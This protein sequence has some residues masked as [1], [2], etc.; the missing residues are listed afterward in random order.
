MS[1]D[2]LTATIALLEKANE[3]G[4]RITIDNGELIV[5]LDE[6]KEIDSSFL[7]E[8]KHNKTQLIA[9]LHEVGQSEQEIAADKSITAF[10]RNGLINIPLSYSQERLWFIDQLEGSAHYHIPAVLRLNGQ[11]N[12][13]ALTWSLQAIV[14]RH[15]VLRTVVDTTAGAAYQRIQEKDNWQLTRIDE[16][17]Y[18]TD[19]AALQSLIRSLI[20]IPFD[21]SAH[22]MLRAHLIRIGEAEHILVA[23]MHHI[24][25]DGWSMGII[26]RELG[27]LYNAY[28]TGHTAVLPPLDIQ[29]ADYAIWQRDYLSAPK[30]KTTLEYWE[31]KLAGVTTLQLPTDYVRP[32]VQRNQGATVSFD[33]D[34][35]LSDLLRQLSHQQGATLFMT[36]L[37]AFKVLLYRYTGQEDSCIGSP[38]AGRNRQELEG[39][40]GI[41]INTLALRSDLGNQ[42][43][44]ISLLQQVK[45]TTLAAYDHQEVPF[46]KIVEAVVKE[47]DMDRHPLFQVVFSLQNTPPVPALR[48]GEVELL[49]VEVE[50]VTAQ[51]DLSLSM[52]ETAAGLSGSIVYNVDLFSRETIV[53]MTTH[54][55]QLLRSVAAAPHSQIGSLTLLTADEAQQLQI[56]FNDTATIFPKEKTVADLFTSQA[57]ATPGATAVLWGT[58]SLT[59]GELDVRSTQLAHYLRGKGI[60]PEI[61]VAVCMTPSLEMIVGIL[62]IMKA[63]GIY[64]P[65]D[66]EYPAERIGYIIADTGANI[67]LSND[68]LVPALKAA[69]PL[70]EIIPADGGWS[71]VDSYPATALATRPS[72]EHLAYVIYTSGSTG[73]PKGVQA[74]HRSL[75]NLIYCQSRAYNIKK[76][77][78][79]LLLSNSSFDAAIEQIFFALL[80]G[81]ALVLVTREIL[82]DIHLFEQLLS[83]QQI[84]HL[85]ATNGFLVHVTPGRYNGL[86]R[87]I[88]GGEQ[89]QVALAEKWSRFVDFYNI[90]GPT[91]TTISA[92]VYRYVPDSLHHLSA[93]PIG[94]PLPN[95][96]VYILDAHGALAPIGVAG[97]I[98]IGGEGVTRGYL[99]RPDLNAEKFIEDTFSNNT[100]AKMYAT[101]DIGKWLPDGTIVFLGRKDEQVKIRG[102][103]IE[104]AEIALVLE[105]SPLAKQAVVVAGSEQGRDQQVY[106]RLTGYI[107]PDGVLDIEEIYAY[108]ES[109][110]PAHMIPSFIVA[111]PEFPL[112]ANGKIDKKALP[113]PNGE[114][115]HKNGYVAPRDKTEQQLAQIWQDLLGVSQ[116]GIHDSF[117]KLGGHSLLVMRLMSVM[118]KELDTVVSMKN[119]FLHPTIAG[120]SAY[121]KAQHNN[122]ALPPVV[123]VVRPAHIPLSYSQERLWFIDQ[124]EGSV[125]YHIPALL[126]LEGNL[127]IAALSRALQTIINR[128]EV[129]RTVIEQEDGIACQRVLDKDLWKLP[130]IDELVYKT[131]EAALQDYVRTLINTP[132]DLSADH[133][134]RGHLI[135]LDEN[136]YQL[137]ITLHHIAADA[138][139]ISI[140]VQ[141]LVAL[142]EAYT[143]GRPLQLAPLPVQYVDYAIWQ[144]THLSG[145]VLERKLDYWKEKLTGVKVLALPVDFRQPPLQSMD[146]GKITFG[147]DSHLSGQLQELSN[148]QGTTLFMT[149]LTVFKV[150]LY[151][152]TGQ[153]DI[154]VGCSTAV[155]PQQVLDGLIGFFVNTLA[156]RSHL[157]GDSTFVSLLQQVKITTLDAYDHADAPFEKVVETVVK[158]RG[159][160]RNPLFRVMFVMQQGADTPELRLGNVILSGDTTEHTTAKFDINFSIVES[161]DGL[162]IGITYRNDLFRAE[163]IAGMAKHFEQLLLSVVENPAAEISLLSMLS[164]TEVGRLQEISGNGVTVTRAVAG[165]N[166]ADLFSAQ[167]RRTPS[168]TALVFESSTLRYHELEEQ[169][170]QLAHHLRNLG[171]KTGTLVPLCIER[172][173]EM[174]VGL[175]GILKAG[176]AY[177]PVDPDYPQ[178]I[179]YML[180]DTRAKVVVSSATCR[181]LFGTGEGM[182]I[183]ALDEDKDT[184]SRY[185]VTSVAAAVE[186]ADL[187]YVIYTSGSTGNP[188]GVMISHGNLLDYL[189]GLEAALPISGCQSFAL[190]AGISTD[191]GNT[192]LYHALTSGGSLHLF[193]R[194]MINDSETLQAY[195]SAHVIDCLKIVPSHWKAL[196]S[197]GD[198]LLPAKL[199]I[200]GGEVLDAGVTA[201][202]F[203]SGSNCMVVNHY[204]PTETTIG[205]LL[206]IVEREREYDQYIPIGRPFSNSQAYV[207]SDRL[208]RCPVGIPGELYIG[209][210]GVGRGYLNNAEL[211]SER[212]IADPFNSG[213][214]LYR[215][216]DI[217]KYLPDGNIMFIG[218]RDDQLK[219]RGYRVELEEIARVLED[220]PG[221]LQG[222]VVYQGEEGGL[223]R[224]TGYV[225]TTAGYNRNAVEAY[226]QERLPDYMIP[227]ALV[228]M[229]EFPLLANGKIDRK[230]LRAPVTDGG[231]LDNGAPESVREQQLAD[232]W[233]SLLEMEQV[234]RQDNFF[235]LGGHS[236]LAIRLVSAIRKTL[237]VEVSIGDIFDYP[238]IAT[239]SAHLDQTSDRPVLSVIRRYN[240]RPDRIPLS[241]SQ[242]R[243]WFID[244]L[245]G[246]V[247]YH[248]PHVLRL[249]GQLNRE[250]LANALQEI[251]N[252]HDVLRTVMVQQ[253]G[254]AYQRTQDK[255]LWELSVVNN[256]VY[257]DDP[258]ALQDFT[259]SLID[260]PFDLSQ[261]HMLRAHLI[262]LTPEEYVL[263]VTMH[264]I[265]SDA[266]SKSIIVRE[267]AELYSAGVDNRPAQLPA[268]SIQYTDY[269]IWQR[270]YLSAEILAQK[271]GYWKNKLTDIA[272]LQLPTDYARPVFQS[273]RGAGYNF[274]LSRELAD[275]L[276]ALSRQQD[277]TL[278]MTLLTAFNILL[279]RY[280]G[281]E[282]ICVG[283]SIA[284]RSQSELEGLIGF[285]IN[286]LALRTDVGNDPA[287]TALLKQVKQ[288]TLEA[289]DHQEIPFERIVEVVEKDRDMSRTSL[290]QVMFE[291]FNTP[292]A[293]GIDLKDLQLSSDHVE[294]ITTL[295]DMGVSFV[296]LEDGLSGHVEYCADLFSRDT[297]SRMMGHFVQLLQAI[298]QTPGANISA[299]TMLSPE[300]EHKL[301]TTFNDTVFFYPHDK[302]L[303]ALFG[304]QAFRKPDAV[305]VW[306]EGNPLSYRE[307]DRQSDQLAHYLVDKGV[308]ADQLVP[309]CTERSPWMLVALLGILKAGGAY[310]PVDPTYPAARMAY[311]VEDC[312]ASILVSSRYGKDK[313]PTIPGVDIVVVE[314]VVESPFVEA[315]R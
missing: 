238:T 281:Q 126:R 249:S 247:Q 231:G 36:L 90:Y 265:A 299:F 177:V 173:I 95:V 138:W 222:V 18:Y 114:V 150:L 60:V 211:T 202:I 298:V 12:V 149:L 156:L 220:S 103:R 166:I 80:N 29:Y 75:V 142:Y 212:F 208:Q 278:F 146:A 151:R 160:D 112:T 280:S 106:N 136:K 172:S 107:V 7:Y 154:C 43:S 8:L 100:G 270:E 215:T 308:K 186:A 130:V 37:A 209:G 197:T 1:Q 161:E 176:G 272:A 236:L 74:V 31:H 241:Y 110:L 102:Y 253:D 213:G 243:L 315:I 88:S 22:H 216:G 190:L 127:D 267:L 44:F 79:V 184:L 20:S 218:R 314:D 196:S 284:G 300:E 133:M 123:P 242:E 91:E 105:Q 164:A 144:R 219:I 295:F 13:E 65:I 293:P 203:S 181:G 206:H 148:Q 306:F 183:V 254:I 141:E 19:E 258:A 188:K 273:T 3:N 33:L 234:G 180:A 45:E 77:E 257:K 26:V 194:E 76:E 41:F 66:P 191:L 70:A 310:V 290:F 34:K 232:I 14:N 57:I 162:Q 269:A 289:Y 277:T 99:N 67:I 228:V 199:L 187:A 193:T 266:W 53:R 276:Q 169:S 229:D 233:C 42:P 201:R 179:G 78:R 167:A 94:A 182:R 125:Q 147:I 89:C 305:A 251:V 248:V 185:P 68:T 120:L 275:Q 92:T 2:K 21:L 129:L 237:Q 71:C 111:L 204:G 115:Q 274:M 134:L 175:L 139:S 225:V 255:N 24:A 72:A 245:T 250:A 252:R 301:L 17:T 87:V 81:A 262:V 312:K 230:A 30:L 155:R 119:L 64:V 158:E 302:T 260:M 84:T 124:M 152:Y 192:I 207:L 198:L 59:Y 46:E 96:Q 307:L 296:E 48:L 47:R 157:Q 214:R 116:V 264:H 143:A 205:K 309:V 221:V 11:L 93:L 170:N 224:L 291:L 82:L 246:S 104:P 6:E 118:H 283:T 223:Q 195:F 235:A 5:Q 286:T 98:H 101:G 268:L 189:S 145:E 85:E 32:A 61:P 153:D 69:A 159:T 49:P 40:V 256:P 297:I 27:A 313:V 132:F 108:L 50:R 200:F 263:V 25:A 244:Q 135:V 165:D 287:F 163:T 35:E 174:I 168:A 137:V 304:M 303:P 279:Y 38:I 39:L 240:P 9:Y 86:K 51:L 15:E 109:K 28:I 226:L 83:E 227:A 63:G 131:N 73:Q 122:A 140:I 16:E 10:P 261:D 128:H 271:L 97:E 121:L 23:T 171:V 52:L 113:Q 285:F 58:S 210:D 282:D 292:D 217:V 259:R 239:L 4:I 56:T 294:H 311:I 288:T 54:F 117:F 62:G 55:K 178:R